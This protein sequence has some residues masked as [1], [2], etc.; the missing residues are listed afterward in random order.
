MSGSFSQ[1]RCQR[2]P[3]LA[4]TV[5]ALALI[6]A[7]AGGTRGAYA[8]PP[9]V[10]PSPGYDRALMESRRERVEAPVI[11]A[12]VTPLAPVRPPHRHRAKR[13]RH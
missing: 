1:R 13:Y 6:V 12:P 2:M 10:Q 9:T 5:A 8:A 7:A 4:A 3:R 11:V